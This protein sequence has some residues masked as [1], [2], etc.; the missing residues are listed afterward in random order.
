LHFPASQKYDGMTEKRVFMITDYISRYSKKAKHLQ[1]RVSHKGIEIIIPHKKSLSDNQIREFILQKKD[2]IQKTQQRYV[3]QKK[4]SYDIK[5]PEQIH[6]NAINQ[7]WNVIYIPTHHKRLSIQT[8]TSRQIKLLGSIANENG[9]IYL[10]K[11]WLKTLAEN[12]LSDILRKISDEVAIP[13]GKVSIRNNKTRWGSCTNQKN[14]SLCCRLLF[15]PPHLVRHILLH[16]LCHTK[17]MHH[18]NE[19]WSLLE[20]LD[21]NTRFH[22]KELKKS[23]AYI[24]TWIN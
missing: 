12:Y 22:R 10:L 16:E 17:I 15:L 23:I 21:I 2:W 9:C 8:N 3:F 19:F 6:L 1:I 4:E 18:G 20:K 11:Q 14:I 5:L 24:P 13:F 7:T